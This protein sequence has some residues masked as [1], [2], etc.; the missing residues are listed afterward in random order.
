MASKQRSGCKRSRQALNVW[1]CVRSSS[2]KLLNQCAKSTICINFTLDLQLS[3]QISI[4]K[5][6]AFWWTPF[7]DVAWD[8]LDG[9]K[10]LNEDQLK[11][12]WL[13]IRINNPR[14]T[15]HLLTIIYVPKTTKFTLVQETTFELLFFTEHWL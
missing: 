2:S 12:K 9:F 11:R 6:N 5:A 14:F 1:G 10:K 8:R 4:W 13:Y 7:C 15:F 3:I